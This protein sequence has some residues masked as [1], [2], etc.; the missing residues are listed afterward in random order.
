MRPGLPIGDQPAPKTSDV[1]LLVTQRPTAPSTETMRPCLIDAAALRFMP[2]RGDH[3]PAMISRFGDAAR[4]TGV[5]LT[6]IKPD[7]S[8]KAGT[9]KDKIMI[10]A[11]QG[12]PIIVA[13]N[14]DREELII[15][16]GIEDAASLALVTGWSAWAAGSAG[17]I[18]HVVAAGC[19]FGLLFSSSRRGY[20]DEAF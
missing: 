5:H 14:P 19:G 1:R 8:G 16:E 17:R 11:S 7:G 2:A 4:P 13:D 18:A 15:A 6:K 10:G 20:E 9:D 3:P 12:Q